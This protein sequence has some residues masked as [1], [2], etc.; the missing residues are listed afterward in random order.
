M[1]KLLGLIVAALLLCGFAGQ[2]MAAFTDPGELI[3]V[4]YETTYSNGIPQGGTTEIATDLGSIESLLS[5]S[6][7]T[8]GGGSNAFTSFT[9]NGV[10]N[11]Q[12]AYFAYDS[13]NTY[14]WI[15]GTSQLK[16]NGND[17]VN[18][19]TYP[20]GTYTPQAGTSTATLAESNLNSYWYKVDG[21]KMK[22]GTFNS[23]LKSTAGESPL[24][25]L[26]AN[27]PITE[28]LYYFSDT[29]SAQTGQAV[30]TIETLA[31]GSTVI[32]P[33]APVPVPPSILLLVP[34]LVGLFGVRRKLG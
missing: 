15:A 31:D 19:V 16:S 23:F 7:Q 1:K 34:A 20:L 32:N 21:N 26:T 14:A 12:V 30:M 33:A 29:T 4:V 10:A 8:V 6:N 22:Y 11:L 18:S 27:N 25:A 5:A 3:R 9:S 24:A 17:V 2:A 13:N 28:S